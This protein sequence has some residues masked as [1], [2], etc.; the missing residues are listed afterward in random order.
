MATRVDLLAGRTKLERLLD[1]QNPEQKDIEMSIYDLLLFS[2]IDYVQNE[3]E[4][5]DKEIDFLIGLDPKKVDSI[6]K[7]EA[8]SRLLEWKQRYGLAPAYLIGLNFDPEKGHE[9]HRFRGEED[10]IFL[11]KHI[12]SEDLNEPLRELGYRDGAILIKSNGIIHVVRAQ[13]TNVDPKTIYQNKHA[14]ESQCRAF[15]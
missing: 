10:H 1:E 2:R 15:L 8:K 12:S 6:K 9:E 4:D 13:L 7:L 3:E 5:L 14:P 11:G